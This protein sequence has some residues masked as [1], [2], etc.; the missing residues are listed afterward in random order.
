MA[1]LEAPT[2]GFNYLGRFEQSS[3]SSWRMVDTQ[4]DDVEEDRRQ[5]HLIDVNAVIDGA[6][7]LA[8]HW[9]YAPEL[10]TSAAM[11]ELAEG[12][13]EALCALTRHCLEAPLAQR[14]SLCDVETSTRARLDATVLAD[15]ERSYPDLE[16]IVP[17]TP[18]QE[19]LLFETLKLPSGAIDPYHVQIAFRLEG[20]LDQPRLEHAW[21]RLI[22]RHQILRLRVPALARERG[23]GIIASPASSAN[24]DDNGWCSGV[25]AAG[26]IRAALD[27]DL[28][29]PFDLEAGPLIRLRL[30]REDDQSQENHAHWLVL[31]NHH[32]LMDGWSLAVLIRELADGYEGAS[33]GPTLRWQEHAE[34]LAGRDLVDAS[35]YWKDYLAELDAP[36]SLDLP[37]PAKTD[38]GLAAEQAQGEVVHSLSN[39][40]S[41]SLNKLASA[42]GLTMASLL[43]GM[44]MLLIAKLGRSQDVVIGTTRSGRTGS[45]ALEDQAIGL[46]AR[47]IQK[48]LGGP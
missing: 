32:V 9:S 48:A 41:E 35:T 3:G 7:G 47:F 18:L 4:I 26:G 37:A 39:A 12:F 17:L 20:Q 29:C 40:L 24:T 25:L 34:Q 13:V 44:W 5:P 38:Q 21:Q 11:A 15:I 10:F 8:V 43:Q 27:E 28:A 1:T 2:L 46:C 42:Q 45:S 31:S 19:G 16:A 30:L 23:L 14:L 6:G 36:V 33:P 22:A